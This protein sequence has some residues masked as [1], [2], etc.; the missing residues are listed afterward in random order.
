MTAS[1][2]KT[3]A[4]PPAPQPGS[5]PPAF[6]KS[7]DKRFTDALT[8][9]VGDAVAAALDGLQRTCGPCMETRTLWDLHH[10]EAIP[11]AVQAARESAGEKAG[12][13]P[14]TVI[15]SWPQVIEQLPEPLRPDP[16]NPL[17]EGTE[18]LPQTFHAATTINGTEVCELHATQRVRRAFAQQQAQ[19]EAARA[20][21]E[22]EAAAKEAALHPAPSLIAA[23]AGV[24]A[25]Q[26]ARVAAT[27][28]SLP[29][30]PT[31]AG[32]GVG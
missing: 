3:P 18:N 11:A 19:A 24:S 21:A 1:K 13:D 27:D 17:G 28:K 26:A 6:R 14:D 32:R 20:A 16:A 10:P 23:P 22:R 12:V 31:R 2:T 5:V 8:Q 9:A 25:S 29:G 7:P 4:D 15:V 30:M